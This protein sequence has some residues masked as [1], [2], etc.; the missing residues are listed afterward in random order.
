MARR[1]VD[2]DGATYGLA[3]AV[4]VVLKEVHELKNILLERQSFT[5]K[6]EDVL[7]EMNIT[8]KQLKNAHTQ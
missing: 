2:V 7:A 1:N 5:G 4:R 8:E 6:N 3:G